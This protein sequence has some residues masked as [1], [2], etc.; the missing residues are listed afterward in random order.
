MD[1]GQVFRGFV[2]TAMSLDE[3]DKNEAYRQEQLGIQK[4]GEQRA[5]TQFGWQE[6]AQSRKQG[7]QKLQDSY[8][9]AARAMEGFRSRLTD[10]NVDVGAIA[11]ELI[12]FYNK[13]PTMQN[14]KH[15]RLVNLNGQNMLVHG[16]LSRNDVQIAPATREALLEG[17]S[18]GDEQ[19]ARQ[20]A[21]TSPEDFQRYRSEESKLGIE[22]GKLKVQQ[23]ELAAKAPYFAAN[24]AYLTSRAN[25]PHQVAPGSMVRQSDG[26]WK[27]VGTHPYAMR[28]GAGG[29]KGEDRESVINHYAQVI[30]DAGEAKTHEEARMKAVQLYGKTSLGRLGIGS[31][32][33]PAL[34]LKDFVASY[35]TGNAA[36]D[37][38]AYQAFILTTM[39]DEQLAQK[40]GAIPAGGGKAPPAKGGAGAE[41]GRFMESWRNKD[42]QVD[43]AAPVLGLGYAASDA[44]SALPDWYKRQV[45]L[46]REYDEQQGLRP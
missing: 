14:N 28:G 4:A 5:Q 1:W 43:L 44:F 7:Q 20:F 33:G 18:I 11:P 24:T 26:S 39:S 23:D 40:L 16:S 36:K 31:Q 46:S 22:R 30:L 3:R 2:P 13:H 21:M 37:M 8:L 9:E 38:Q 19:L 29:G 12:D 42:G 32:S 27:Q 6:A 34:S 17:L 15:A 35:G 41:Q 10:E 45:Q 25:E